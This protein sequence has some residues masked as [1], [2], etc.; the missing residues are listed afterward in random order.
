MNSTSETDC[1]KAGRAVGGLTWMLLILGGLSI[2]I[3]R[4]VQQWN[5]GAWQAKKPIGSL[6]A[7]LASQRPVA[8]VGPAA[9]LDP[10]GVSS[11]PEI[12]LKI[13]ES[14]LEIELPSSEA[15]ELEIG[16]ID[17]AIP[18]SAA[19]E[20]DFPVAVEEGEVAVPKTVE[21]DDLAK[22]DGIGPM[23]EGI[24]YVA[25]IMT[26]AQLAAQTEDHLRAILEK[27][28][29]RAARLSA[30]DYWRHQAQLA[31]AGDW[32]GWQDLK[33]RYKSAK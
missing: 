24:L 10:S 18:K 23:T 11:M 22:L 27:A 8:G 13:T 9:G 15:V 21:P 25:G 3:W 1:K 32:K 6:R 16:D 26:Y 28:N 19:G 20:G 29:P 17:L 4:L 12:E 31:A 33:D 14:Q 5:E 7:K 2:L 30:P